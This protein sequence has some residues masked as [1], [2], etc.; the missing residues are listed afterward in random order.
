MLVQNI[1]INELVESTFTALFT[2]PRGEVV[3][4]KNLPVGRRPDLG[5]G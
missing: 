2:Y 3:E 4:R 5:V 1:S